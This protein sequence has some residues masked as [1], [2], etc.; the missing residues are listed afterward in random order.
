MYF[1]RY[2]HSSYN[3]Y[4]SYIWLIF[5]NEPIRGIKIL[6]PN[7]ASLKYNGAKYVF[8]YDYEKL[9]D[10]LDINWI[11]FKDFGKKQYNYDTELFKSENYY[12]DT[13]YEKCQEEY[14]ESF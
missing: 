5:N 3:S 14:P 10:D 13:E 4:L 2:Y 12:T 1:C 6:Y 8:D 7:K 9:K 11:K